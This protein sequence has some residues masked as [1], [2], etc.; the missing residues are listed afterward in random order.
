LVNSTDTDQFEYYLSSL[1]ELGEI[2]IEA[3]K[4][5]SVA[6]GILR[7][8]L[9]TIMASNGAIFIFHKEDTSVSE[10][11]SIGINNN[12]KS[13]KLSDSFLV[14]IK[15]YQ[16]GVLN[17]DKQPDWIE[18][19]FK[20][21]L[22][23]SSIKTII[24][25]FHKN[26]L[27][28]IL[29]VGEKFMSEVFTNIDYKILEIISNHLTKSLFNYELIQNV[30][31]KKQE[32]NIKLLELETLF[33]IGVAISSVLDVDELAHDVLLRAVG[34]LNA[35]KGMFLLQNDKS[36]ILDMLSMFNWGENKFL[37]SKNIDVFKQ[38]QNGN[39]GLILTKKH[40]TDIQKKI[41]E[42]N[43]IIVPLRAKQNLLG[44]M[45]LC[46]KETRSGVENFKDLDLD[47][48]TS[49]SNQ[50][51][52]AMDN[53]KLFK[54]ITEA[55][56]FNENILGSIAT[57]VITINSIGE[58]DSINKAGENILKVEKQN[59][60]G[61][62][63]MYIFEH[64][65]EIIE[66]ISKTEDN[67][68]IYSEINIPFLTVSE[69][70]IINI[71]VAPRIDINNSIEGVVIAIEDI[72]DIN[73]V[74]NTFKRYV[75]KQV[76]DN[77]LDDETN[78]NLGGENREV[79]ILFTDIRGFTSM[80][81]KMKP[82]KVVLTLN[83]YFSE[84][85]DIV[86]KHNGTLDKIIGDELMIVF[87]A[88]L[89]SDDDT[90]RALNTA[91]EMQNKIEDL[92]KVRKKRKEPPILVGAGI[93]K[94][95]VVSGNIGSRDMMDYTVVGDTVNLGSRLCSAASA[96]EIIVSGRVKNSTEQLFSF[97]ELKPI[98]VKGKKDKIDVY[99][100]KY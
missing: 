93:N 22:A 88:P 46:D 23:K 13:I 16:Y 45:I 96:G 84:M 6:S 25:L 72:S 19:D 92:N 57:G 41:Q 70:T 21:Y 1:D 32:L 85:I 59:I 17:Y 95:Q 97:K 36:P 74:K 61:N 34:I 68:K 90:E 4:I 30:E 79:T 31:E 44:Y 77:L 65:N 71:S 78:L 80:A 67:K 2:L 63:Y 53:A 87:G 86:F 62:H 69:D 3:D 10:L 7:L 12:S 51:A 14:N 54:E 9:G 35:S 29:C 26:R 76:V 11:C 24:P 28:G 98:R 91:I 40:K 81:E 50:A 15:V 49:L 73:K 83:E 39:R 42:K 89:S 38:M 100:V 48:L 33:D 94:G 20:K 47:I 64:D 99:Q 58:I 56:Q 55:K 43:L 60:L 66:L 27:L 8:T 18:G 75:S 5:E 37:L 82:E 52:V